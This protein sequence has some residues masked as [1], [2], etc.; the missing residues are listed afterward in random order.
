V[1]ASGAIVHPGSGK[2]PQKLGPLAV[3]AATGPDLSLLRRSL[4]FEADEGRRLYISRLFTASKRHPGLSLAGPMVGAPYAVMVAETL[5]AW[6]AR[7]LIF[8]G[9]CGAIAETVAIGDIVLP[10]SAFIDEGTSRHY[11]PEPRTSFASSPLARK[12]SDCCASEKTGAHAGA[13]WTTDAPYRETPDQLLGYR[14]RGALAV[15][16]EVSALY[17]VAAFRRVEAAAVLVVSDDLSRLTWTPGF[18]D[19]RFARGREAAGAIIGRLCSMPAD[20]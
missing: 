9:W 18:K 1:D 16:M 4:A 2:S 3:L 20:A 6:G 15:E 8:L 10:T 17:S 11:R 19:P 5:I 13:V 14:R 12:I 7:C